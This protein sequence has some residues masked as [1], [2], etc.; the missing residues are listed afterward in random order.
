MKRLVIILFAAVLLVACGK[1][2]V[3]DVKEVDEVE[4][5]EETEETRE[6]DE[7]TEKETHSGTSETE[8]KDSSKQAGDKD[9]SKQ[10]SESKK[11]SVDEVA[12]KVID[13]QNTGDYATLKKYLAKNIKLDE[14][15]KELSISDVEYP[16][17]VELLSGMKEEDIEHRF[18]NDDDLDNVIVGYAATDYEAEMSYTIEMTFIPDGNS[19]KLKN[20][21]INK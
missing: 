2:D 13:A 15:K 11:E 17:Q 19:W 18:T 9:R 1:K 5:N 4:V 6:V 7:K 14:N 21:Q 3:E 8:E 12:K 20:M 10:E 16:G